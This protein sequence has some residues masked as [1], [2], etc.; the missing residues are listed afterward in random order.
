MVDRHTRVKKKK[1]RKTPGGK[2]VKHYSRSKKSKA[3][4]MITGQVLAGTGNQEKSS[5][6]KTA[7][8]KRRPSAAFGGVLS[9]KTR[10]EFWENYALVESGR[11]EMT[12]VPSKIKKLLI[13]K[14][15]N[16]K[17]KG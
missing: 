11:K 12:E 4:D 2:T 8:T 13:A 1:F 5:V 10:K 3:R 15:G 14:I 9:G 6:R 17:V 7:K 16:Q